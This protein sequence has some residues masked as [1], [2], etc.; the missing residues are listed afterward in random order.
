MG[1]SEKHFAPFSSTNSA[2]LPELLYNLNCTIVVSTYQAGKVILISAHDNQRISILPRTFNK[3]M[4]VA[5]EGDKMAIATKDEIVKLVDSPSLAFHY[6]NHPGKYK[7]LF[8]PRATYYT[9]NVDMHD[10]HFGLEGLWGVNTSFSC[11]CLIDDTYS[12]IP[13]WKPNF[14]SEL[15]SEDRC[16]LNGLAMMNGNPKYVTALGEGNVAQSWRDS[17]INGGVLIDVDTNEIIL[18]NLPMPHS[19]LIYKDDLYLLL[20]AT[21][22][23]VRV[24]VKNKSYTVMKKVNGFTRGMTI[25]DDYIFIGTSKLRQN[26]STFAKL[27]FAAGATT[28]G[29]QVIHLPTM[30]V[31]GEITFHTSVDEIYDLKVVRNSNKVGILNTTNEIY[32]HSL[33]IPDATFWALFDVT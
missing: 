32:K 31:V 6:P 33:S 2:Q 5:I 19:P 8:V 13:K 26:S 29:I 25:V 18:R 11:L 23:L 9:G 10:I 24:D 22:E 27:S 17:I 15:V 3:A 28:A 1:I 16:H 14:I 20:S 7:N 4:G 12:F 30:A 21:G